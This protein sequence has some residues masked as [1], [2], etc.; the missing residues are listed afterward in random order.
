[1]QDI[2]QLKQSDIVVLR[3]KLKGE[4]D[5]ICPICGKEL[6]RE[7]LD[8]LHKKRLKGDGL[9]RGVICSQCNV[10]L[11]KIEN[12]CVRYGV[13]LGE[14]PSVLVNISQYLAKP[15][16]PYLHPSEVEREPKLGK[17]LFSKLAKLHAELYPK[18]KPL[19]YPKSAK[20][21]KQLRELNIILQE[22]EKSSDTVVEKDSCE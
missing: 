5:G 20:M 16:L 18:V 11:A 1:M 21:T 3:E 4:Q 17:R 15:R 8:H 19:E 7:V 14:L 6:V 9:I 12:S 22:R 10:F 13:K 2:Q